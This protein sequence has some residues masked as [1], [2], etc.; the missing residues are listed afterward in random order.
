MGVLAEGCVEEERSVV[1]GTRGGGS[2]SGRLA[3]A[4]IVR[5]FEAQ[6]SLPARSDDGT[7][8][9]GKRSDAT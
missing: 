7:R 2:G 3:P 8:C 6:V 4:A 5:G 9:I 1:A